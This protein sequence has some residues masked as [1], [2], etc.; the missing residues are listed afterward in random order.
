MRAR[1]RRVRSSPRCG[2]GGTSTCRS[3]RS[4]RGFG[5][6]RNLLDRMTPPAVRR[7]L[8]H[9][10][11]LAFETLWMAVI[12]T[13]I[14]V[15]LS[16]PLAFG[17]ARNTTPHPAVMAVCRAV[18]VLSRA[19]PD[20]LFARDLRAG[21][22]HRRAPRHPRPRAALDR[23]DRQALRRRDRADRRRC[24]ARP[25]SSVGATQVAGDHD[26][27]DPAGDAGLHRHVAV[28]ARHQPALG[29]ACSASSAPAASACWLKQMTG[30][31]AMEQGARHRHRDLRLH[32][33]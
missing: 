31:A 5:D 18:I 8:D 4:G 27:R 2:R 33:A 26:H 30:L 7:P 20:L 9:T 22:R 29:D 15:A 14:A 1:D 28:P 12:G 13:T 25:C 10:I 11:A 23:D 21:A 6:M 24:R 17:A 19:I 32:H 3:P 16:V